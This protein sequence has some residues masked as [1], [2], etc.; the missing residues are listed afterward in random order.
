MF[1]IKIIYHFSRVLITFICF[2]KSLVL[3]NE[4]LYKSEKG[5][6]FLCNRF[7]VKAYTFVNQKLKL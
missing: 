1:E 7:K 5:F 6:T 2:K 3:I 4:N